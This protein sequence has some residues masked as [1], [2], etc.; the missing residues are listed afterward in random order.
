MSAHNGQA[1]GGQTQQQ[2]FHSEFQKISLFRSGLTG[3]SAGRL[4]VVE[5][6]SLF[7]IISDKYYIQMISQGISSL[8]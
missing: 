4:I 7:R 5:K 3:C 8:K 6:R 1:L 2:A